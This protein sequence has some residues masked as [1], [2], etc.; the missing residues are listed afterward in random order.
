FKDDELFL[1]WF[2]RAY[3]TESDDLAA[4][5]VVGESRDKGVDG[6][7]IDDGARAVF[8]CQAKYR[9]TLN[10]VS[11]KRTDVMAFAELAH[12]LTDADDATF[13]EYLTDTSDL[14]ATRLRDARKKV[15][16]E[17]YRIWLY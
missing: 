9:Q 3:V 11:E 12:R 14:V 16:K 6:L 15:H 1:V 2:L 7:L 13:E 10:G 4:N 5:A 8:V 17:K